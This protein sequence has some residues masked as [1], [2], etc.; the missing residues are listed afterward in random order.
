MA[1]F[2]WD[3]KGVSL[4][5]YLEKGKTGNLEYY[6]RLL[7]Q[8]DATIRERKHCFA[9][10]KFNF[11]QDNAHAHKGGLTMAK[12]NELKYELLNHAPYSPVCAPIDYYL[13]PY[14]KKFL[15]GKRFTSN[16]EAIAA[17]NGYFAELEEN[18]F[19]QGIE[20]LEKR[21]NNNVDKCLMN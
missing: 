10:K 5:D 16:D 11:H 12:L 15:A 6:S 13:F 18:H 1:T 21:W 14:L 4:I 3:Y 2:F 8:L 7:D 9:K 20:L 17:V 19:N